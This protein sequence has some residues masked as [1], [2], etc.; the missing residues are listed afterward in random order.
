MDPLPVT[1]SHC[2]ATIGDTSVLGRMTS[3]AGVDFSMTHGELPLIS[4]A[5][6]LS[7]YCAPQ[8]DSPL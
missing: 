7:I 3:D 1:S 2:P 6:L 5:T 8:D 4:R